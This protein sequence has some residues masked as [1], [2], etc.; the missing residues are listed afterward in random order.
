MVLALMM[1]TDQTSETF[2]FNVD[3]STNL[4]VEGIP[5]YLTTFSQPLKV[6]SVD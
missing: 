3:D 4:I 6:Y 1:E 2:I 5:G